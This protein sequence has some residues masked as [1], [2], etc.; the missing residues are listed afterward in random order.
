MGI[1]ALAAN[2]GCLL[3]LRRHRADDINMQSSWVCS[4]NDIIANVAV[5]GAAVGVRVFA[6]WWPDVLVG[7][8]IATLFILSAV[9]VLRNAWRELYEGL[10][11]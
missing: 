7:G 8:G 11:T 10:V 1:V 5:I 9:G 2:L 4:R 3:L 6:S